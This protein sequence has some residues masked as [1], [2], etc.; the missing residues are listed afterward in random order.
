LILIIWG[1]FWVGYRAGYYSCGGTWAGTN[2]DISGG[3][4]AG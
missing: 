1:Q 3:Y 4:L 2:V